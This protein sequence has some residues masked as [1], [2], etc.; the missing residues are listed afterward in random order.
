MQ[1]HSRKTSKEHFQ[2]RRKE[3]CSSCR[4]LEH[5]FQV[6]GWK[7]LSFQWKVVLQLSFI[8]LDFSVHAVIE[9]VHKFRWIEGFGTGQDVFHGFQAL[10]L[11][12]QHGS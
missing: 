10:L 7:W 3:L 2:D 9:E 8:E 6:K 4:K 12:C 5:L 11:Q 1:R